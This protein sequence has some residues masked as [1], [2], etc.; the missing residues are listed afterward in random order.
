MEDKTE[1]CVRYSE[2]DQMSFVYHGNYVKYFEIGRIAWL[3]KIGISY[4]QMEDDG[5]MLPVVDVKIN[6]R[7]SAS[8][9]DKL[10]LT[11]K[12][13]RLPSYM[14]EFEYEII[15]N[16]DLITRGYTKLIFLNSKT[17]KPIKCPNFILNKI[18]LD[19]EL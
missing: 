4:K 15:R 9:D 7:K 18:I 5:I 14:I 13:I 19:K 3:K 1:I 8:F 11:T 17:K 10:I 16:D 12:L 6:F 2:T